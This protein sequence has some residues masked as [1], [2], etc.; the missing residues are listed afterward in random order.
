MAPSCVALALL[1]LV[2]QVLATLGALPREGKM[3]F[4][5][6]EDADSDDEWELKTNMPAQRCFSFA[7]ERERLTL[8]KWVEMQ[9]QAWMVFF[10]DL[11]CTGKYVRAF[12]MEGAL[13]LR[14]SGMDNKVAS[15]M[16]WESGVYPTRGIVDLCAATKETSWGEVHPSDMNDNADKDIP[17]MVKSRTTL[18]VT[19]E[20]D[21]N[22]H[23]GIVRS[24]NITFGV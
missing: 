7:C 17:P 1:V 9:E 24:T 12:G 13:L 5:G 21:G 10:D 18:T 16:V 19:L 11:W 15:F 23:M 8:A 14:D 20:L 4:Y 2:T 22:D 3:K 6:G